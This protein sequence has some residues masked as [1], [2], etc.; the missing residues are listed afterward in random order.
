MPKISFA[1]TKEFTPTPEQEHAIRAPGNVLILGG[2]GTGKTSVMTEA[3]AY[4][5]ENLT[6]NVLCLTFSRGARREWLKRLN[7]KLM[8]TEFGTHTF[9][10]YAWGLLENPKVLSDAVAKKFFSEKV[11]NA[12][13]AREVQLAIERHKSCGE[14]LMPWYEPYLNDYERMKKRKGLLDFND[15]ILRALDKVDTRYDR[16]FVDEF[17]DTSML[18]YELLK[19]LAS[20]V[21]AMDEPYQR[22][23]GWRDADERNVAKL[24]EDFHPSEYPLTVSHRHMPEVLNFLEK[25]YQRGMTTSREGEGLVKVLRVANELEEAEVVKELCKDGMHTFILTRERAQRLLYAGRGIAVD[26][27]DDSRSE[28]D[29]YKVFNSDALA[30]TM[31]SVKGKEAY[32]TIVIGCVEGLIPHYRSRN[33]MEEK[34]LFYTSC[35]RAMNELYLITYGEPSRFLR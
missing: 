32:R 29:Y 23:Y 35:A 14:E 3:V 12:C 13:R 16:V 25:L 31:H 18:Q 24:R 27:G 34:N 28:R 8:T 17:Q 20:E 19:K 7:A 6:R 2:P 15:L 10:N 4:T 1:P 21:V 11:G 22:I 5:L 33:L 30:M 9:H 26:Y